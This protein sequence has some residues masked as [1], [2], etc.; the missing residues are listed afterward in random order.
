MSTLDSG[1]VAQLLGVSRAHFTDKLSKRGDFPK[2]V[3]NVSQ[4]LR[5]WSLAEVQKWAA[6]PRSG[7]VS[8]GSRS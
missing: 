4:R 2:P 6:G 5:R 3:V 8:R 1:Q 7:P